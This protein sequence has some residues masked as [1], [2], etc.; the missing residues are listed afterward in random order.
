MVRTGFFDDLAFAP[1]NEK[2]NALLPEEIAQVVAFVLSSRRETVFDE[3][4]LSPLRK[5]LRFKD[6]K[7]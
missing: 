7:E 5:V 4:N 2:D 3:I 1:G 6:E